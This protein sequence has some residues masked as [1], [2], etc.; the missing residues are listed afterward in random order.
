MPA[1]PACK[2]EKEVF[3]FADGHHEDGT[4]FSRNGL[5]ACFTCKGVGSISDEH[6]A[7]IVAGKKL[8]DER[9]ARR[10]GLMEASTRLGMSPAELSAIETGR[11]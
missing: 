5:M 4:A 3:V 10:E 2:G 11:N 8:R 7:R 9:V 1:C 6:A